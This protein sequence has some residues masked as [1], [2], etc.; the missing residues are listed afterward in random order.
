M[1]SAR[2]IFLHRYTNHTLTEPLRHD[3]EQHL[4]TVIKEVSGG[5]K[6]DKKFCGLK[7]F[8]THPNFE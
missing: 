3:V 6:E 2:F 1:I 4:R 5:V 8:F 7:N